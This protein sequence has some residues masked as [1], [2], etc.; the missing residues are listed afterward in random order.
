ML[1]K[2]RLPQPEP[3]RYELKPKFFR[4]SPCTLQDLEKAKDRFLTSANRFIAA[5]EWQE[6]LGSAGKVVQESES[7]LKKENIV[8]D[9]VVRTKVESDS[10]G[11]HESW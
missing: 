11:R 2:F 9:Y 3:L 10:Q 1:I 6:R 8:L 4:L 5:A 7:G